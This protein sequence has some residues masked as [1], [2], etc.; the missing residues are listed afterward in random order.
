MFFTTIEQYKSAF[1]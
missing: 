1:T